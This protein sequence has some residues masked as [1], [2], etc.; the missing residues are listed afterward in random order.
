MKLAAALTLAVAAVA[1]AQQPK[2]LESTLETRS[3]PAGASPIEQVVRDTKGAA[4][5]AWRIATVPSRR[6]MCSIQGP[7]ARLEGTREAF[8]FIRVENGQA[9]RIRTFSPDCEIDAGGLPVLYF[10][11]VAQSGMLA[12]LR[13]FVNWDSGKLADHAVQAIGLLPEADALQAT[14]Q[15][16]VANLPISARRNAA[17]ALGEFHPDRA[18]PLLTR[19]LHQDDEPRMR[20]HAV[21]ALSLSPKGTA[22]LLDIA[23]R[24]VQAAPAIRQKAVFWLARS[25]LPE[26]RR[27]IETILER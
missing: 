5:I 8:V 20:E 6:Q 22:L 23:N 24:K 4:W 11:T 2:L 19:I 10:D 17:T 26:A 1:A 14:E 13:T 25:S 7:I 12:F 18:I 15:Y 16:L 9:Q 27:Y 3:L 21:Y